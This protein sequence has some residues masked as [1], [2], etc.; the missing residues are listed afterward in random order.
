MEGFVMWMKMIAFGA[1]AS[2]LALS[3][4]ASSG[5]ETG[6]VNTMAPEPV[7][8]DVT[9]EARTFCGGFAAIACPVGYT[10]VDDPADGCDPENGGADC[11]GVCVV[12]READAERRPN[13]SDCRRR[14]A[15][16]SYVSRSPD[17]CAATLFRCEDG[18][19]PFFDA[20]GCG[21]ET[22]VGQPCGTAVCGAGTYCCNASCS[23]CVP[24]GNFCIQIACD[25]PLPEP[26]P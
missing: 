24:E 21:C 14:D 18:K 15:T 22:V 2:I 10:C 17:V 25:Q 4:C 20:C 19:Q 1:A 26:L 12:E 13:P 8:E 6:N 7:V 23:M 3:A 16:R 9:A 5:D 11:G